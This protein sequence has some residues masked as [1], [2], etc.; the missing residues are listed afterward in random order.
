MVYIKGRDYE[1]VLYRSGPLAGVACLCDEARDQVYK[2]GPLPLWTTRRH[3]LTYKGETHSILSSGNLQPS[4]RKAC[5]FLP[6]VELPPWG[7][8]SV[9]GGECALDVPIQH[10]PASPRE[11]AGPFS[12][13]ELFHAQIA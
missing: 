9:V 2:G 8:L 6:G 4:P 1:G 10:H 12:A 5:T 3:H 13:Q 7:L 11:L